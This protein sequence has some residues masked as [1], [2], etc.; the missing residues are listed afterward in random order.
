M[1]NP[2]ETDHAPLERLLELPRAFADPCETATHVRVCTVSQMSRD[3]TMM[4][5]VKTP[6]QGSWGARVWH[7]DVLA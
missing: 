5:M 2:L 3:V 7:C 6:P 1:A 4:R